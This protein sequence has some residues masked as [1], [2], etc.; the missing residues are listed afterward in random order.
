[1]RLPKQH[2]PQWQQL[3]NTGKRRKEGEEDEEGGKGGWD[4]MH[5]VIML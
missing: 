2:Q 3:M 1:M 4:G 5:V